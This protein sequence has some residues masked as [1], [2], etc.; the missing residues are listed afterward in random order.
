MQIS[1]HIYMWKKFLCLWLVFVCFWERESVHKRTHERAQ[2][3]EGQREGAD[4]GSKLGPTLTAAS[5]VRGSNSQTMRSW[6]ELNSDVQPSEPLRLNLGQYCSS[7]ILLVFGAKVE[8]SFWL[9]NLLFSPSS[10]ES[11]DVVCLCFCIFF[12]VIDVKQVR[13]KGR[14]L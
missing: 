12:P 4:R 5:P 9:C 2:V 14:A 11:A 1:P 8:N 3:R 13:T 7:E 6:P 10:F